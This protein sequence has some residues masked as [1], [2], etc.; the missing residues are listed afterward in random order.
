MIFDK[1]AED[2]L[3]EDYF[4]ILYYKLCNNFGNELIK[5]ESSQEFSSKELKDLLRFGDILSNST[6][7]KNRNLAYKIICLLNSINIENSVFMTYSTAILSRLGNFPAINYLDYNITLPYDRRIKINAKKIIQS[8]KGSE[9][10][11]FTDSQYEL[12]K[13]IK[14][15]NYYSFSGPTSMGKSFII[16]AFIRDIIQRTDSE[17]IVIVVPTKALITQFVSDINNDIGQIVRAN[18]YKVFSNY[19]DS[20]IIPNLNY[21][22]ILTP[23]RL[24]GLLSEKE[25]PKLGILFV[26]EAHKLTAYDDYRSITMY[27]AIEKAIKLFRN[28]KVYFSSPNVKNP[29][30]FLQLFNLDDKK[31]F[32]TDETPV[33]QN[34]FFI[35]LVER[36]GKYFTENST[37]K[38]KLN[39]E[40]YDSTISTLF[41][42]GGN[43]S[44]IVYTNSIDNTVS[45]AMK[46]TEHLINS[47]KKLSTEEEIQ[48]DK[49]IETIKEIIHPDYFLIDCLK[50]G[51]G[52]H[53]GR[54]PHIIRQK[55]EKLFKDGIIKYLFC[56]STLLEGVNLPAKNVFILKNKKGLSNISKID[57]WNLAGR[58]GR[59]NSE[60]SGNIFCIREGKNDWK[61]DSI[62]KDKDNITLQTSIDNKIEKRIKLIEQIINQNDSSNISK[63]EKEV[64]EYIA[65]IM[66]ID[67]ME[68]NTDYNSPVIKKLIRD[69]KFSIISAIDKRKKEI[70]APFELIQKT[71]SLMVLQQDE[72]Y[73]LIKKSKDGNIKPL[74]PEKVNYENCL[75][76]LK[77]FHEIYQ[78]DKYEKA[79]ANEKKLPYYAQLMNNWINGVS[80][81]TLIVRT[82]QYKEDNNKD[83]HYYLDGNRVIEKF[84]RRNA[85][86]VNVEIN[87][88][89]YDIEYILQYLLEKYFGNYYL[90]L[91]YFFGE[92]TGPNWASFL[93]FGSLNPIINGLQKLGFS[94]QTAMYLYSH[95]SNYLII[96]ENKLVGINAKGLFDFIDTNTVYYD[97][98]NLLLS[99]Y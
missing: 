26:D 65:N 2:V 5:G 27:L 89:L 34:L 66:F 75:A 81:R 44:N 85:S 43:S 12:I 50:Q 74:L 56:T 39:E 57:F 63:K 7:S 32:K 99:V 45:Y 79:L 24:L 48:I 54:L 16:K 71:Y 61:N 91:E 4:E 69:E 46:F 22:F 28:I 67:R 18:G 51:V 83:I 90:M 23:E 35:D 64:L 42:L 13:N 58:A 70:E 68:G 52:F 62:F 93:E 95:C 33:G 14:E 38:I 92:D 11:Y 3:K 25:K 53:F 37:I 40:C 49:A 97:E 59:L 31:V 78:W 19:D 36:E 96:E 86:H 8:V 94:R 55:V 80:L 98:V 84:S 76:V 72:V 17:N 60:L 77:V 88:L 15:T 6:K 9:G 47:N 20:I 10:L 21:I 30:I 41:R 87:N 73:R 82:L 1:L 29:E